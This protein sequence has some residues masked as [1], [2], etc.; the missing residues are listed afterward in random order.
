[1]GLGKT[2]T[3]ISLLAHLME[4]KQNHGPFCKHFPLWAD[5]NQLVS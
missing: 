2:L 1:M 4:E 3:A 5:F